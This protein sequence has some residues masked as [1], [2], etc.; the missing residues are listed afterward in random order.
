MND[1]EK[2]SAFEEFVGIIQN[3]EI[4]SDNYIFVSDAGSILCQDKIIYMD[5][6]SNIAE[7]ILLQEFD[8]AKNFFISELSSINKER[9]LLHGYVLNHKNQLCNVTIYSDEIDKVEL[10]FNFYLDH[11][12]SIEIHCNEENQN[13][14]TS[15]SMFLNLDDT[16]RN[17]IISKYSIE[18]LE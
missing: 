1:A 3:E 6:G 7:E 11:N 4:W 14:L 16:K 8:K 9:I 2:S 12:S 10:K 17:N 5:L 15:F 13:A 18:A